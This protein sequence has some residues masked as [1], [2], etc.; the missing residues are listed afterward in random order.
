[1]FEVASLDVVS[2]ARDLERR[3][4]AARQRRTG[5]E[6]FGRAIEREIAVTQAR[7][8]RA[9]TPRVAR[10]VNPPPRQVGRSRTGWLVPRSVVGMSLLALAITIAVLIVVGAL[11]VSLA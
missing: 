2:E 11:N 8:T 6:P 10:Q 1:M 5:T 3:Q 7:A 4:R 9:P